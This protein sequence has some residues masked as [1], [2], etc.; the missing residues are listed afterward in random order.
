M[1]DNFYRAFED[2]F[3]GPRELIKSRLRVYLPFATPLRDL[4]DHAA[5]VDLGCGRGEWLEL[6]REYG[7]DAQGVDIDE[8][9]LEACRERGLAAHQREALNFLHELPDASQ[10]IVSGFHIVEHIPFENL[11]L[12]VREAMRVL[13]PGGL[14]ILETPN[15]E[16]LVVATSGFYVDP[17]HQ[18]P[19]PSQLLAFLTQHAGFKRNKVLRLQEPLHADSKPTLLS[20]LNGVSPDY[21]IVAQKKGP[22]QFFKATTPAFSAEYGVTLEALASAYHN[23]EDFRARVQE[24]HAIAA[25][26]RISELESRILAT[27]AHARAQEARAIAAETRASELESRILATEAHARAQEARAIAAETR[28]SELESRTRSAEGR[29]QSQEDRAVA[30][31]AWAQSLAQALDQTQIALV[32]A[33]DEFDSATRQA[34]DWHEQI[35]HLQRSISWRITSP[36]RASRSIIAL[37]YRGIKWLI[38]QLVSILLFTLCLPFLPLLLLVIPFVLARPGLRNTI[39]QHIRHYPRLRSILKR[40]A[41]RIGYISHDT[42]L[43]NPLTSA[44]SRIDQCGIELEPILSDMETGNMNHTGQLTPRALKI[45]ESLHT[46]IKHM[47]RGNS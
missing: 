10:A 3:R 39:G 27:E 44:A 23:H 28:A 47:D 24:A 42:N 14:L 38:R 25:K 33:K 17:T 2:K 41:H 40:L 37:T 36:L 34:H 1:T 16:N 22:K 29:A 6:L 26:T 5:A 15:P 7:Y 8:G 32:E 46:A 35:Q 18:R 11:K 20:V 30:A 13:Q 19:I 45:Y 12:L 43:V 9:M 31:E 21:A 4:L